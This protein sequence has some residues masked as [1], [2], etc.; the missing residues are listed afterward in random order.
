MDLKEVLSY[1][2]SIIGFII[3]IAAA[4][5]SVITWAEEQQQ[6]IQQ[7]MYRQQAQIEAKATLIHDNYYQESRVARK[8]DQVKENQRELENLLEYIGDDE[9]TPRQAR[10]IDYLDREI[11]RLRH[12]IEEIK[13]LIQSD[14]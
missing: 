13:V 7:Q 12:E 10:E 2:K 9:P 6:Q 8:E 14:E 3:F 11:A 4:V 5:F 1:W